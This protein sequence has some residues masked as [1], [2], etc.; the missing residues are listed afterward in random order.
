ML[1][2]I[3]S[4]RLVTL[5]ILPRH[6]EDSGVIELELKKAGGKTSGKAQGFLPNVKLADRTWN[7]GFI[8]ECLNLRKRPQYERYSTSIMAGCAAITVVPPTC[9][10]P[11]LFAR[12]PVGKFTDI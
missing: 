3:G 8:I 5:T 7:L 12:I 6:S 4:L 1:A 2:R 11:W 9:T 10:Y